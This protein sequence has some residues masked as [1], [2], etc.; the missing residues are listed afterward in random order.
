MDRTQGGELGPFLCGLLC[1]KVQ[2]LSLLPTPGSGLSLPLELRGLE[3]NGEEWA[4]L[5]GGRGRH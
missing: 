3:K 1:V 4:H 5:H 2:Q